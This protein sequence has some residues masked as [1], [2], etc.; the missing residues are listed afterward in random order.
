MYLLFFNRLKRSGG[1]LLLLLLSQALTAQKID[2]L[3]SLLSVSSDTA[4]YDILFALAYEYSDV[5]DSLSLIYA[6]DLFSLANEMGD[7]SRIIK[8]GRIMSGE[9][10]RLERF[11]EAIHVAKDVLQIARRH[12]N[13]IEIKLLL[14]SLAISHTWIAEYD[15]ALKY[16]FESLVIREAEGNKADISIT[17]NNIG[18]IYYKINDFNKSIEYYSRSLKLKKEVNDLHDLDRLLINIGLSYNILF[19]Y[20]DA[21]DYFDEALSNC[22]NECSDLVKIE[23]QYGLGVSYYGLGNNIEAKIHFEQSYKVAKRSGHV[24]YQAETLLNI[25]RIHVDNSENENAKQLLLEAEKLSDEKSYNQLLIDIYQVFFKLYNKTDDYKNAAFYQSKYITLKDSIYSDN[26]IK[27]LAKVNTDYEERENIKT[28]KAKDEVLKLK[29]E[30]IGRQKQEYIF[31]F[32]IT[33]LILSLAVALMW[34]GKLQRKANRLLVDSRANL[35]RKVDERTAELL[36]SNQELDHFIYKTSHDIRGPLATFKGLCLVALTDVKDPVGLDLVQKLDITAD[37]LNTIL[38]RLLIVNQINTA[39]L[40][41]ELID[42][43]LIIDEIMVQERKKELPPQMS[44][45]HHIETDVVLKS[46]RNLV[47][48]VLENLID[49][50]IKFYDQSIRVTPFVDIKITKEGNLILFTVI[51]NG[52]GIHEESKHNI[53]QMFVRASE[54]SETGGIGLY[55]SRLA[56]EKL[57]GTIELLSLPDKLTC[58]CVK[59]PMDLEPVLHEREEEKLLKERILADEAKNAYQY[60]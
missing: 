4:R 11:E 57:G 1:L 43:N 6:E 54:R 5:N 14:N 30:I 34:A 38:N 9:L 23:S 19:K 2:S 35:A 51:D 25:A 20:N 28:I 50:S 12:N 18:L 39:E 40:K 37:K 15:K 26:L 55:L 17:L 47:R 33:I 46:D 49:N 32:A 56:T 10:R 3:K 58:F 31:I 52:I 42:F 21:I 24:R 27:N 22:N 16:N 53:F 48:I 44:I 45:K 8:A 59:M 7:S 60:T 29:E 36:R 13:L 41:P